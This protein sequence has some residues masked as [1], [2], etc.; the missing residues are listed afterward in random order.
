[1]QPI[2]QESTGNQEVVHTQVDTGA[3]S[4][5]AAQPKSKVTTKRSTTN[6]MEEIFSRENLFTALSRVEKNKGA[7]GVDG[8]TV[9]EIR[10][11][12]KEQWPSIK[13]QLFNQTY[14]PQ[15]VRRVDIPK[16]NGGIRML[17]IPTVLDRLIQQ[18][19]LQILTPIFDPEFSESSYGFRP[20]RG[21]HDAIKS[22][23]G[24]QRSGLHYVVDIDLERFF[25][26]VNHDILM[27]KL[28]LQIEDKRLL[29][30]IRRYL[31]TGIMIDGLTEQ[32]SEGTP[33][34]SPLSPI[35]SNI[36]LH[37]LDQEIERRRLSFARYADDCNIY[38]KTKRAGARI[39]ESLRDFIWQKLRLKINEEKSKVGLASRRKFLG[40][41][42]YRQK[43]VKLKLG[44]ESKQRF[45]ARIRQLTRGH[46]QISLEA[47]IET[48]N[49]Y[50]RGWLSYFKLTETPRVLKELDMWIRRR[51]RM[52]QFKIWR[53]PKTR[54]RELVKLG[55]N[56]KDC[57][58][59]MRWKQYWTVS[60]STIANVCLN[61]GYFARK[62]LLSLHDLW[63]KQQPQLPT[64]GYGSVCPVV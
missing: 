57:K 47:R 46:H 54:Q 27:H 60:H 36:M 12:L 59:V 61:N 16:P 5:F 11:F 10:L 48:L 4:F 3:Q 8:V 39:L 24:F 50:L 55:A 44:D 17:G 29:R 9:Q 34:G 33:Q 6:L 64:A 20:G 41:S 49:V 19:I 52:C 62:G 14:R 13:E 25:D 40:Y 63:L 42:S 58:T 15:P 18:A 53:K 45:R 37:E 7:P 28:S 32:R 38:V 22:A 51:L 31:Q 1:M 35:L 43:T 26:R 30:L 21:A 2:S 23:L 56:P